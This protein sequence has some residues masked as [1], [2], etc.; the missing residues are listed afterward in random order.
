MRIKLRVKAIPFKL[1]ECVKNR[2]HTLSLGRHSHPKLSSWPAP[3]NCIRQVIAWLGQTFFSDENYFFHLPNFGKDCLCIST[4][5]LKRHQ[6][7]W[8][9]AARPGPYVY[10]EKGRYLTI[11]Y[12]ETGKKAGAHAKIKLHALLAHFAQGPRPCRDHHAAHY[13]CDNPR[14]LSI[15]HIVWNH[16]TQNQ[17][18]RGQRQVHAKFCTGKS[19]D[20]LQAIGRPRDW[21]P[22]Q[23]MLEYDGW[24]GKQ[25]E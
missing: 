10:A 17:L 25:H 22:T 23:W 14:C 19:T 4:R 16:K 8:R 9:R 12:K 15:R 18:E 5:K 7:E 24:D 20:Y 21:T 3:F 1:Y 13:I 2:A 11:T 6:H